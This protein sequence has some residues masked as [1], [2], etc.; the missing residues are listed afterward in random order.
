MCAFCLSHHRLQF[1][2]PITEA[3]LHL[4]LN[5]TKS[6]VHTPIKPQSALKPQRYPISIIKHRTQIQGNP[7]PLMDACLLVPPTPSRQ[8]QL[9]TTRP[10]QDSTEK[11]STSL[12]SNA[13]IKP[14]CSPSESSSTEL[15][16]SKIKVR[17][18]SK[19]SSS[20]TVNEDGSKFTKIQKAD[21]H[22]G[23]RRKNLCQYQCL[24]ALW[25]SYTS[26][27]AVPSTAPTIH[28]VVRIF[29]I[30]PL[31]GVTQEIIR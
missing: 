5:Y 29:R 20:A 22:E 6:Q 23:K 25:T 19:D 14:D 31:F 10:S 9:I 1:I 26:A 28:L 17:D 16:P 24:S 4:V 8:P 13:T 21:K 12:I 3:R 30:T 11:L 18:C 15:K 7:Q 27:R 2:R